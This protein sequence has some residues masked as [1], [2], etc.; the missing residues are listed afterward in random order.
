MRSLQESDGTDGRF[1]VLSREDFK[2]VLYEG[3]HLFDKY[4]LPEEDHVEYDN[5]VNNTEDMYAGLFT[6][7]E[8][9]NS[10]PNP[11]NDADAMEDIM[12]FFDRRD[13]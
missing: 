11:N 6:G 2:K 8:T 1:P 4:E 5:K 12:S 7:T 9:G 10:N 13:K 3:A